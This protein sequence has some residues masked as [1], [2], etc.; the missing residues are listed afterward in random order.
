MA[1]ADL[2]QLRIELPC[3]HCGELGMHR[4]VDLVGKGQVACP[5]CKQGIDVADKD[6][7]LGI[8]QAFQGLAKII[9]PKK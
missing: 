5:V 3:P 7:Q 1:G 9:T 2:N 8:H 6:W 4:I